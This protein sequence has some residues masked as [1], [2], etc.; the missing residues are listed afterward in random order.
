MA[1]SCHEE[2]RRICLCLCRCRWHEEEEEE[3]DAA[4]LMGDAVVVD[5]TSAD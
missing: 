5:A 4:L 2:D 1:T 3:E